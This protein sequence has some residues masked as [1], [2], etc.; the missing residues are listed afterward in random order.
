MEENNSKMLELMEVLYGT[1]AAVS[2]YNIYT[3]ET[4]TPLA[5]NLWLFADAPVNFKLLL[6]LFTLI[7]LAHDWYYYHSKVVD[8]KFIH[9][10][11]QIL[12]LYFLS[13]MFVC[14]T[15]GFLS[16]WY[17]FGFWYTISGILRLLLGLRE[18]KNKVWYFFESGV[19]LVVAAS[20]A[21]F[22]N[23]TYTDTPCKNWLGLFLTMMIVVGL[24][25]IEHYEIDKKKDENPQLAQV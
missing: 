18:G 10:V 9:Y 1:V 25:L 2:F 11:P 17:S 16:S 19:H 13:Q 24:W 4:K 6:F 8:K 7:I 20:G 5:H 12:S 23:N 22:L 21:Y 14:A 15:N 3:S